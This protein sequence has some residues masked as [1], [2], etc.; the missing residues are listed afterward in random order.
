MALYPNGR[1]TTK[2]TL[3][4]GSRGE[5]IH[6]NIPGHRNNDKYLMKP[7]VQL[8]T[9]K[10]DVPNVK[11]DLDMRLPVCF[12]YGLGIGYNQIVVPKGRIMALDPHV[13]QLDFDDKKSWNVL[14]LANGGNLVKRRTSGDTN[15]WEPVTGEYETTVG[16]EK[17]YKTATKL[18]VEDIGT[19]VLTGKVT[20]N[21]KV[22]DDYI[23]GN[24]PIGI[25]LR[26][27]YTRDLDAQNGMIPGAILTDAM[28][29]LPVF[30]DKE[31]AEANPW[32]SVYG[33]LLPGDLVK[34]DENGRFVVS[35]LS[36]PEILANMTAGQIEIERQQLVGQVY[37]I[38][39][40]LVPA[41]AARY[42][43]WA[44]SD[45]M[46]FDQYNPYLWRGTN[47]RGE[48]VNYDSP[49]GRN[50]GGAINQNI[51]T[52][53]TDPFQPT[54]YGHDNTMSDHD[55]HMMAST[56]RN[57][58]IRM[59]IEFELEN[60]IPGVSDGYNVW[61]R[62]IGPERIQGLRKADSVDNYI[63]TYAK[64]SELNIE[65]GTIEIAITDKS[66]KEL[67]DT[68]FVSVTTAGQTLSPSVDGQPIGECVKVTYLNELQGF[69]KFEIC[70]PKTFH[71]SDIS[72]LQPLN[73]YVR[74][75]KRGLAGVPSFMDW[76]GCVGRASILLQK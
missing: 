45:R 48:D 34:S 30:T 36:R 41:G 62:T 21:G 22:T 10:H 75:K 11:Y 39:R 73:I 28:V 18:P 38:Q 4:P 29:E 35:P 68:D 69:I 49:Y 54:G 52:T 47:R 25:I 64:T 17:I 8:S 6:L 67:T 66:K 19:D 56:A 23:A 61:T 50:G 37:A 72:H 26:N 46:N 65:K 14:T 53:G 13:N 12:R 43:Q 3:M 2:E 9:N 59:G 40:D 74:Y 58:D 1:F 24:R 16:G 32:G 5:Y 31:K 63:P 55:L 57:S 76:D 33:N 27:E 70:D 44:L 42:V 71:E 7:N 60:G 15:Q 51:S 20:V